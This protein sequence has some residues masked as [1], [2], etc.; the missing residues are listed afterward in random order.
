MLIVNSNKEVVNMRKVPMKPEDFFKTL[1]SNL[2]SYKLDNGDTIY[3]KKN[4]NDATGV[5]LE[6]FP[7]QII[8]GSV[9]YYTAANRNEDEVYINLIN[10]TRFVK[11]ENV[12]IK[13]YQ[14]L[15]PSN[16]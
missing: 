6:N 11:D 14:R 10:T 3:F 12:R 16:E 9:L 8:Y 2:V 1:R 7:K 4:F 15:N 13:E 5:C